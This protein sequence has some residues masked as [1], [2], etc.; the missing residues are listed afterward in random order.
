MQCVGTLT[1]LKR[2]AAKVGL[3]GGTSDEFGGMFFCRCEN[4]CENALYQWKKTWHKQQSSF[5]SS[6]MRWTLVMIYHKLSATCLI[7]NPKSSLVLHIDI[8]RPVCSFA[9]ALSFCSRLNRLGAL[10]VLKI[11][12]DFSVRVHLTRPDRVS[13]V[14]NVVS[15]ARPYLHFNVN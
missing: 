3:K 13:T 14:R 4:R 6:V 8:T 9:T 10:G 11:F 2:W 1:Q 7:P 12:I 5:L 15:L